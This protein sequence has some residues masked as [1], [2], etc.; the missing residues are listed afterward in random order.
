[1]VGAIDRLT[2]HRVRGIET[3]QEGV[4][5]MELIVVEQ[6]IHGLPKILSLPK[7]AEGGAWEAASRPSSSDHTRAQQQRSFSITPISVCTEQNKDKP[8]L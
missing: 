1:M 6:F 8:S 3:E 2:S 7:Q 5:L 4:G